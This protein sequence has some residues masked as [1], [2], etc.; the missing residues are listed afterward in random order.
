VFIRPSAQSPRG[1]PDIFGITILAFDVVDDPTLILIQL[2]HTLALQCVD[3]G[4]AWHKTHLHPMFAEYLLELF[5][6]TIVVW[7]YHKFFVGSG[8][9]H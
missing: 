4:V 1:F 3:K 5:R 9:R 6:D 7:E 2:F 8:S